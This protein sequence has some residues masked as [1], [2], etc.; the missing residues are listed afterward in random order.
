MDAITQGIGAITR[1]CASVFH[2][3]TPP[4]PPQSLTEI[5]DQFAEFVRMNHSFL[6]A[7]GMSHSSLDDIHHLA[8]TNGLSCK[9]TGAGGGGC[10]L[11]YLPTHHPSIIEKKNEVQEGV[12]RRGMD[13]FE[14]KVGVDGVSVVLMKKEAKDEERMM[15][16]ENASNDDDD[17]CAWFAKTS[18][19]NLSLLLVVKK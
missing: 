3:P 10:A 4:T 8:T 16:C 9:I 2:N 5:E 6:V 15:E 11:V 12:R 19:E 14:T 18:F 17:A 13:V 7:A 1:S